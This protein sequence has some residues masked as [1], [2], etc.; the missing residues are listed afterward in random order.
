MGRL[1]L[2]RRKHQIRAKQKRKAKL[3]KLRQTYSEAKNSVEKGKILE[4]ANKISPGLSTVE[5]LLPLKKTSG[6]KND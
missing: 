2:K 3:S 1:R 4:K 6:K 5:F